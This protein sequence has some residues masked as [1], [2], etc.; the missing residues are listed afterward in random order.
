MPSATR[1]GMALAT[2]AISAGCTLFDDGP[3]RDLPPAPESAAPEAAL[4]L[5]YL[6]VLERLTRAGPAEQAEIAL[7]AQRAVDLDATVAN[8]LRLGLVLALPGHGASDPAAARSW[9]GN[10]LASPEQLLPAELA[11]AYVMYHDLNARLALLAENQ[12]LLAEVGQEDR[13][14]LLAANRRLQALSAENARVK[15]ELDEA[16]AKLEAVADLERS[17]AERQ[18]APRSPPP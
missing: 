11:L 3:S 14:R 2:L 15:Q 4:I 5:D 12:R 9:L 8:Q 13:E 6:E 10:L 17:L 16:R 18:A 7:A 1:L